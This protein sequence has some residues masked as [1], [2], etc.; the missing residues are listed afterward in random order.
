MR[1]TAAATANRACPPPAATHPDQGHRSGLC[2]YGQ[3]RAG[4]QRRRLSATTP[5]SRAPTRS[6]N[7]SSCGQLVPKNATRR[8]RSWIDLMLGQPPSSHGRCPSST[9]VWRGLAWRGSA[10][11]HGICANPGAEHLGDPF[12]VGRLSVDPFDALPRYCRD[13]FRETPIVPQPADQSSR[14]SRV[15]RDQDGIVRSGICDERPQAPSVVVTTGNPNPMAATIL[16]RD[17]APNGSGAAKAICP[18][19]RSRRSASV[20]VPGNRTRRPSSP[21]RSAAGRSPTIVRG[22][23]IRGS[24]SMTVCRTASQFGAGEF[25]RCVS[26]SRRLDRHFP[27]SSRYP[28]SAAPVSV[29]QA[30]SECSRGNGARREGERGAL[31]DKIYRRIHESCALTIYP[32]PS[33]ERGPSHGS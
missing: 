21:D 30:S 18:W 20:T 1:R 7:A 19:R 16:R 32:L 9:G 2:S 24:N 3:G 6:R 31:C 12:V 8:G 4:S 15:I 25:A 22:S 13:R 14:G 33:L 17:P 28:G 26:P 23:S 11:P 29:R 27:W 5:L 10:T